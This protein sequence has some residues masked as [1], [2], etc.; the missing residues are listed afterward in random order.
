MTSQFIR[1]DEIQVPPDSLESSDPRITAFLDSPT[2]QLDEPF[3]FSC[4]GCGFLCCRDQIIVLSLPEVCRIYWA[5]Q[6]RPELKQFLDE[7]RID[8]C[9]LTLG[10]DSGLPIMS[11]NNI[12][13]FPGSEAEYCPF[14]A[15]V[16]DLS[17]KFTDMAWCGIREGR[18]GACRIYPLGR[19][20][21]MGSNPLDLAAWEYRVISRCPGFDEPQLGT[22]RP[23]GYIPLSTPRTVRQ[24]VEAQTDNDLSIELQAYGEQI[25]VPLMQS[26]LHAPTARA[27]RGRLP[28]RFVMTVLASLLF[29]PPETPSSPELDHSAI[30]TRIAQVVALL[31]GLERGVARVEQ[32]AQAAQES[33]RT[34]SPLEPDGE[35]P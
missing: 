15:P 12:P 6:R 25:V 7:G 10:P 11:I 20:Q 5:I 34:D 17:G 32:A 35:G 28:E 14:L 31:P 13:L 19:V 16:F 8:W 22:P 24:F 9:Q 3:S 23:P 18:P 1:P 33:G 29:Q 21:V 27:P 4:Q 26:G 30:M 2:I